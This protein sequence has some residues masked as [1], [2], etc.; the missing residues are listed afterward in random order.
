MRRRA[1]IAVVALARP[2][3]LGS[4]AQQFDATRLGVPVTMASEGAQPPAG[5]RFSVT[6]RSVF[7]LWGVLT[8]KETSLEQALAGQLG[9][10]TAVADLTV[11][12]RQR[13]SDVLLTGLTLGLV[14]PRSVT[15]EGVVV[16]ASPAP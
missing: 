9:N 10:G 3:V 5:A 13:W 14:V 4:C 15:Y 7:A 8:L 16:G 1:G 11:R 12:T 6:S 2:L